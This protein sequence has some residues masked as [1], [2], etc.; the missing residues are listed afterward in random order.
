MSVCASCDGR[1][2]GDTIATCCVCLDHFHANEKTTEGCGKNCS[3]AL[4]SEIRVIK[5]KNKNLMVYRCKKCAENGGDSPR[6]LDAIH[7]LQVSVKD[8]SSL[9]DSLKKIINTDIP[10]IKQDISD[11]FAANEKLDESLKKHINDTTAD[12]SSI[13]NFCNEIDGKVTAKGNVVSSLPSDLYNETLSVLNEIEYRKKSEKNLIIYNVPE[14]IK[15]DGSKLDRNHDLNL[16]KSALIKI[17]NLATALD[18]KKVKRLGKFSVNKSR[19]ILIRMDNRIDVTN[20]VTHWRLIPKEYYVSYDLTKCQRSQ[21]NKLREEAEIFNDSIDN[22][23]KL[24]QIVKFVN[25]SPKIF[26]VKIKSP[27]ESVDSNESGSEV[28]EDAASKNV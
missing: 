18:N 25:G 10:K 12:I 1:F 8:L 21:F 11:L 16:V 14:Q 15:K 7:E 5:L 9:S 27:K 13:K 6:L 28:F 19:P 17:Q 22:K 3:G 2:E 24:K 26:T 23:N 20:I 4:I